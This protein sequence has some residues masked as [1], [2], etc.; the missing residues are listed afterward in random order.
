MLLRNHLLLL[1]VTL[2]L[3]ACKKKIRNNNTDEIN[4]SFHKRN[5]GESA[6]EL[7]RDDKFTS[8]KV[9]IQ[10]MAGFK[11]DA[12][13]VLNLKAFLQQHLNK[14]KGIYFLIRKIK[15]VTDTIL[16]GNQVDNITRANRTIYTNNNQI[17]VYILYTNGEF[18]NND[19]LGQA[20]R[21]TSIVI[22]GKSVKENESTFG[23]PTPTTLETELLLHE[24]GHLLGLVDK[25]SAMT[26]PHEDSLN[27]SHCQN[28]RCVMHWS[29]GIRIRYG[30]LIKRP[31]PDFDTACLQDLKANGGN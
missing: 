16:T 20:F 31:Y 23:N 10:Y 29:I 12:K 22:Y 4:F 7:L 18:E 15:P 8:L 30:P 25:G 28:Q 1:I 5:F 27:E 2:T 14:P 19:I 24:M 6:D 13:A 9:E 3:F 11:P 26:I 21:N 17:A